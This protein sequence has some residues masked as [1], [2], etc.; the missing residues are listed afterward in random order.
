MFCQ[1]LVSAMFRHSQMNENLS[2]EPTETAAAFVIVFIFIL[3]SV[4]SYLILFFSPEVIM[5]IVL[6]RLD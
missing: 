2:R 3:V 5:E 6:F 1:S 4:L